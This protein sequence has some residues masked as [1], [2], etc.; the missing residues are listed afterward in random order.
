MPCRFAT[1]SEKCVFGD[2]ARV[3]LAVMLAT[4]SDRRDFGDDWLLERKFDGERCVAWKTGREV[5]LESRTGTNLTD[6]YPEVRAAV[7]AQRARRL[8]LDGEIVAFDGEQTSFG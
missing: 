5:R 8:L 7:S 6:T 1:T 2:D 3:A 4:L